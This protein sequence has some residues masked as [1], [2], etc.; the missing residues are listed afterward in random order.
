MKSK[1]DEV[2][3]EFLR[4]ARP[5]LICVVKPEGDLRFNVRPQISEG[6]YDQEEVVSD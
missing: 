5:R 4:L 3:A 6:A 1:R 2:S